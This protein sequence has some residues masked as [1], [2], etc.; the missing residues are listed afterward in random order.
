MTGMRKEAGHPTDDR[1]S[2]NAMTMARLRVRLLHGD[3]DQDLPFENSAIFE[4]LLTEAGYDVD[5]V[6]FEGGHFVP[7]DLVVETILDL[8]AE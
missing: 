7:S 5:L 3:S 2:R 8:V 4:T 1:T 6:E